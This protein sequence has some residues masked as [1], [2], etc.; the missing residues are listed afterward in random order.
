MVSG[1]HFLEVDPDRYDP[2]AWDEVAIQ[3]MLAVLRPD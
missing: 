1:R 3:A 2:N